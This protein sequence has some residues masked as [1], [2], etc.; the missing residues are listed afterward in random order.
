MN[1]NSALETTLITDIELVKMDCPG[2]NLTTVYLKNGSQWNLSLSISCVHGT[3]SHS[4]GR[5]TANHSPLHFINRL[6]ISGG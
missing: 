4:D 3:K 1:Y 5:F 6:G 2:G